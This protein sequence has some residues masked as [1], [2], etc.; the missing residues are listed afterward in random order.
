MASVTITGYTDDVG[1]DG[2]NLSLSRRRAE[3]VRAELSKSLGGGV[4]VR[5][6]GKGEEQPVSSND[7]A[8]GRALNRRV[9]I[10]SR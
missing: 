3:A 5:A 4:A 7:T 10:R 1:S 9:E 8:R 2:Y 6:I